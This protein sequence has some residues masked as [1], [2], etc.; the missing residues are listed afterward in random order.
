LSDRIIVMRGQPGRIYMEL[1][2]DLPRPR[3]RTAPQFQTMK[4]EVIRALDLS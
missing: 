3:R 1:P 4:E 2:V